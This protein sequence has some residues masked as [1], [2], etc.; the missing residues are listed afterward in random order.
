MS[1]IV[2]SQNLE[3]LV[4]ILSPYSTNKFFKKT[5]NW[6][7]AI[8]CYFKQ[9]MFLFSGAALSRRTL[10]QCSTSPP[11]AVSNATS[12]MALKVQICGVMRCGGAPERLEMRLGDVTLEDPMPLHFYGVKD[13]SRLD[14]VK[15]YV[16]IMVEN[17]KGNTIYWRLNRKDAIGEVK[18]R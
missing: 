16:G 2:T 1:Y 13:G 4:Q 12:V 8:A 11:C 3:K 9:Y 14:M 15:P 10:H 7:N 17:N 5:P 18:V 6:D